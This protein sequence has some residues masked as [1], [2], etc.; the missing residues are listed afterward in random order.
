[1]GYMFENAKAFNQ[2]IGSWKV[3]AVTNMSYMFQ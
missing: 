1:M 2:N 3:G